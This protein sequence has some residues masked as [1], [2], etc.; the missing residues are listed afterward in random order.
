M[1]RLDH[2]GLDP[3]VDPGD[4]TGRG[5]FDD[6]LR[7]SAE[8]AG[9][10]RWFTTRRAFHGIVDRAEHA[11]NLSKN[12]QSSNRGRRAAAPNGEDPDDSRSK[13]RVLVAARQDQ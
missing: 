5:L 9:A 12:A 2:L 3:P 4:L 13:H 1:R 7:T 6:T 8:G 11:V 10:P